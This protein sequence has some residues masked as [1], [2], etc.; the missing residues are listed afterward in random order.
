MGVN[1]V[2]KFMHNPIFWWNTNF[3]IRLIRG[4]IGF[5]V[6]YAVLLFIS[7]YKL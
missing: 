5:A 7:K 1:F 4:V 3:G 6:N 2:V